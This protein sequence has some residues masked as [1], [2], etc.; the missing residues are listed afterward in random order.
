MKFHKDGTLPQNGEIFVFGSNLG[1]IHGSGA[2]RVAREEFGA[3][4]LI[5]VGPC[6]QSYAIPT[7]NE[8]VTSTLP[9]HTI[10][11]YV[12]QFIE[13]ARLCDE[14]YVNW[15]GATGIAEKFFVTSIGCGLAGYKPEQIAPMFKG[16]P[17]NCSFPDTWGPYLQQAHSGSLKADETSHHPMMCSCNCCMLG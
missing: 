10:K 13:Y 8:D 12:E 15:R 14:N 2:A 6:G 1:G 4:Y 5:G 16:A 9:L 3:V 17:D 11:L 7:K